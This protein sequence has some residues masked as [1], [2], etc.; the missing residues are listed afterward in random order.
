MDK[1]T[2][3]YGDTCEVIFKSGNHRYT[4]DG[5]VVPGVTGIK[6]VIAKPGLAL[7]PLNLAMSHLGGLL[8]KGKV[9]AESDLETAAAAFRKRQTKG[10]DTGT[11]IHQL[12]QETLEG[13]TV[14]VDKE[15]KE[16]Q[17]AMA[18]FWDWYDVVEPEVLEVERVVY[19]KAHNYAGTFDALLK[20]GGKT[21][22]VD[23][24]TTNPSLDAPTG[25]YPDYFIQLGGY[26]IAYNEEREVDPTMPEIDGVMIV[27]VKKNGQVDTM[28]ND[29]M[30]LEIEFIGGLWAAVYLAYAALKRINKYTR[31]G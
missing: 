13:K 24:K 16:V 2:L 3:L 17:R 12:I 28:S 23:W 15:T 19:S 4:V 1:T 5:K 11:R 10:A 25:I 31:K 18:G 27:S 30:G 26:L 7:W 14:N 21:Y 20:I 9:I 6:D 22:L 29:E 8:K